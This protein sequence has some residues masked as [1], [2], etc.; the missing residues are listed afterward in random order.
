MRISRETTVMP[1]RN[2]E[3]R[4]FVLSSACLAKFEV[5]AKA[6]DGFLPRGGFQLTPILKVLLHPT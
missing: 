2:S 3:V 6:G 4:N 5:W 1:Q